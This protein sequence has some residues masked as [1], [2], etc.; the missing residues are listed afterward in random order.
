M[1]SYVRKM[2][3]GFAYFVESRELSCRSHDGFRR[4]NHGSTSHPRLPVV[5]FGLANAAE[6][7]TTHADGTS[8]QG[9]AP[10]VQKPGCQQQPVHRCGRSIPQGAWFSTPLHGQFGKGPNLEQK[11]ALGIARSANKERFSVSVM[12]PRSLAETSCIK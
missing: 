1:R 11:H 10:H 12:Y 9:P 7:L 8:F 4:W 6:K 3:A 2:R 5:D